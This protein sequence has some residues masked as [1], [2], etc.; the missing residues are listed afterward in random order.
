MNHTQHSKKAAQ[1]LGEL[2][3]EHQLAIESF[4][5]IMETADSED[6]K[7]YCEKAI[8]LRNTLIADL[9]EEIDT[10]STDYK[11]SDRINIVDRIKSGK[12]NIVQAI[13]KVEKNIVQAYMRIIRSNTFNNTTESILRAQLETLRNRLKAVK[14]T[15]PKGILQA[16]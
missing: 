14:T 16:A 12:K 5:R 4:E 7:E 1:P 11:L 2:V 9:Q 10:V 3:K 13:E 6:L 15:A 8:E